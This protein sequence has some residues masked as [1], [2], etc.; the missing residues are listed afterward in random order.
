MYWIP[1]RFET[2]EQAGWLRIIC[3][4]VLR[5]GVGAWGFKVEKGDS[6]E[7]Q[8]SRCLVIR[9]LSF[10]CLIFW[11]K[12]FFG[13]NHLSGLGPPSKFQFFF[14]FFFLM[15][16]VFFLVQGLIFEVWAFLVAEHGLSSCKFF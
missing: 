8:K 3:H 16:W 1:K 2:Q 12:I 11:I 5:D 4:T 10:L 13:N 15:C 14:F 9:C 7:N 6:W